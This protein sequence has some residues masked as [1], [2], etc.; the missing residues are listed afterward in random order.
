LKSRSH[1]LDRHEAGTAPRAGAAVLLL[2]LGLTVVAGTAQAQFAI[3]RWIMAGG[4]GLSI[5]GNLLSVAGTIGQEDAS[6]SSGGAWLLA[7]GFW[8]AQRTDP[9]STP[10]V[11]SIPR[12]FA[13]F[14]CSPNPVGDHARLAF[15]LPQEGPV[16][17]EVYSVAG[18]RLGTVIDRRASPGHLVVDWNA[19]G[20]NGRRLACGVY[21]L[22]VQAGGQHLSQHV[23]VLN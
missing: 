3:G 16:R 10:A 13:Y 11:S 21:L 5:S 23:V 12:R 19:T 7:G 2:L 18:E 8:F 17:V 15:D 1:P 14:P 20:A 6:S 22:S 4:G 9:A